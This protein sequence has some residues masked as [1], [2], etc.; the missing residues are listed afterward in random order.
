MVFEQ[1]AS[2][3]IV[4]HIR[5]LSLC[6]YLH[7]VSHTHKLSKTVRLTKTCLCLWNLAVLLVLVMLRTLQTEDTVTFARRSF[8]NWFTNFLFFNFLKNF[9]IFLLL[10]WNKMRN[11]YNSDYLHLFLSTFSL[12]KAIITVAFYM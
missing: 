5:I 9:L 6:G 10:I 11:K 3:C 8:P 2:R 12:K 1:Q 7:F 4:G